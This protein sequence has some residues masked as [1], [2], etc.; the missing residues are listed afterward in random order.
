MGHIEQKSCRFANKVLNAL[1]D[2]RLRSHNCIPA[3]FGAYL[4]PTN[5]QSE[6]LQ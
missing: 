1:D 2:G 5:R 4:R 3:S 6:V